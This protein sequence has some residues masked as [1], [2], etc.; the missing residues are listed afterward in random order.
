MIPPL[1]RKAID[2]HADERRP[3]GDF[4]TA[5]LEN[6]LSAAFLWADPNSR[7]AMHEIMLYVCN[8]IPGDCWG[9]RKIVRAWLAPS[10]VV[11]SIWLRAREGAA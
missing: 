8:E 2:A 1:V 9:S 11:P 7:A 6:D 3:C 5:V 10:T 4:V